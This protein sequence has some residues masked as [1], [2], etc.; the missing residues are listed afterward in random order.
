MSYLSLFKYEKKIFL[1]HS[2]E[3]E[4]NILNENQREIIIDD[5]LNELRQEIV[6]NLNIVI[7]QNFDQKRKLLHATLNTLRP[8]R[9]TIKFQKSLDQLLQT[10]LRE[11]A[12]QYIENISILVTLDKT[13]IGL[14]RGD[15][16]CLEIDAI[17]NAANAQL[18]GCF[19]PLH[20][21][22][23]NAIHSAAGVQLRDDCNTIMQLQG[24]TEATGNAKITRAYN[25]PSK[26][27]IHTVGPIIETTPSSNQAKL[28]ADCYISCLKLASQISSIRSIAFC[29]IS[30]GIFGY[31]QDQ[32]AR[33][34]VDTVLDWLRNNDHN[35]SRVIFNV[36]LE[37]DYNIYHKILS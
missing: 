2:F 6:D 33:L 34:A 11:K 3:K 1:L 36:F 31:P 12:I 8:N 5:L 14:W 16:T 25:L 27:V 13:K 28:L 4:K 29:C 19:Q 30:T 7:P 21:C 32:A 15:I 20:S 35:L 37:K 26:Y 24:H 10:E 23:D 22:I 9:L 17:V 18:L